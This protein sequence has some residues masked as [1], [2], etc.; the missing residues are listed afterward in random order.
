M[1]FGPGDL[2]ADRYR[3]DRFLARGGMGEVYRADDLD[4]GVAVALKTIRPEI[5]SNP[6]SLRLFKQEVL[7]ARSVTHSNVC[8]IY[9][10][11]RHRDESRDVS[12]LTMEFLPGETLF[13]RIRSRGVL[14]RHEALPIIRQIADALDAAHRAGIV[15]RDFKSPNVMIVPTDAGDRAVIT[16]FG[17]A[18]A[19][20]DA[21]LESRRGAVA[22]RDADN[23]HPLLKRAAPPM[24]V[25]SHSYVDAD[26]VPAE[27][28][29]GL[30]TFATSEHPSIFGTPEYMAPEQVRGERVGPAA[31]LYALGIVLFEMATATLPFRG[32]TPIET[33]MARLFHDP[34]APSSLAE[35]DPAWETAILRL[36]ARDPEKR[37]D[38]ATDAVLALQGQLDVG[39]AARHSLPAERDA[40]VGREREFEAIASSLERSGA[41][42]LTILGPGGAGKTRLVRH[43]GWSALERWTGGVWF[44]DLSEVRDIDGIALAVATSLDVP[45]SKGDPIAQLGHAIASRGRALLI[46]DNFERMTEHA[47][48]TLGRWI[49]RARDASF[50]I[51]S[52]ERLHLQE[53]MTLVLDPLDP[54]HEGVDL[55]A[56]R[57]RLHRPDFAVTGTNR[58]LV[59]EIVR[60]LDGL[61]LAI[62]L[63]TAKLRALTL[64]QL[65]ERLG[66]RFRL[67]TGTR[68]GRQGTLRAT[69][70][71]SWEAL[72]PWEQAALA[73][74]SVFEGGF[75]LEA[76]E[77]VCDLTP[78]PDAPLPL[79][80]VQALVDKSWLRAYV[81]LDAPRFGM[82][83]SLQEYAAEK[84]RTEGAIAAD[85]S[86]PDA[87]F[88]FEARHGEYFAQFGTEERVEA[89]HRSG[90]VT[91]Q[92]ALGLELDNIGAACRRAMRRNDGHVAAQAFAASWAVLQMSGPFA[93]AV[94][95]GV[96]VISVDALAPDARAR[97][98]LGLGIALKQCGRME[99]ARRCLEEAL[100]IRRDAG[101]RR[102]EGMVLCAL[103]TTHVERGR[104]EE[105]REIL[106]TALAIVRETGD[107]RCKGMVLLGLGNLHAVQG[108]LDEAR[109]HYEEA[110]AI[111]REIGDRRYE[112]GILG[113]LANVC[114]EQGRLDEG[115]RNYEEALAVQREVGDRSTEGSLLG[116][117]GFLQMEQGRPEEARRNFEAALAIHRELGDR[118]HE[119]VYL[120]N[121]GSV[122]VALG[123]IE[124]GR[125]E[126]KEALAIHREVGNRRFEAIILETL[127]NL[128][129]TQS[130]VEEGRRH[131]DEALV[132][133]RELGDRRSEGTVLGISGRLEAHDGHF[134]RARVA[135]LQGEAVLRQLG[136][137]AELADLL[138]SRGDFERLSG[139]LIAARASLAEAEGIALAVR[140][141]PDS[142]LSRALAKLRQALV[143]SGG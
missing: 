90:G 41:P 22:A 113:N 47:D 59:I 48:A 46:L 58:A 28:A 4:L 13:A 61:P 133:H 128:H 101:D 54:S 33:A 111:Q 8:R 21:R 43:Y 39:P 75:T 137:G 109:R 118:R 84:L 49:A 11:G 120:G 30:A 88:R 64:E 40:F 17:L 132:I 38:R 71:W 81:A 18:V 93:A 24:S 83:A 76:A 60:I 65:R 143:D 12:F 29:M 16:D 7:L 74:A 82:Y 6:A 108:R 98:L 103:A 86:G 119:G 14:P 102:S 50:L 1:S 78:W 31:D 125:R 79:D 57:A 100:A 53:E 44:C 69:L 36:L 105:A 32:S 35:I 121:L 52:R 140:V 123:R 2:V 107:R 136:E 138:C 126:C 110:L 27:E 10:L 56:L 104:V 85:A 112:G 114:A 89:L 95:L 135:F 15:H 117:L 70:D 63:A 80:V 99:E 97:V 9:D 94:E 51:T 141:A 134:E 67:L 139:D 115:L 106:E 23:D 55:F 92:K 87:A 20:R 34:P 131:F 116:N 42:L 73:Q 142:D 26:T 91:K 19:S 66:D 62:E 45:L 127:G 72:Q 77:A 129:L 130:Q 124:D 96:Q 25:R 5:A 37:Y 68:R 3:I 122:H